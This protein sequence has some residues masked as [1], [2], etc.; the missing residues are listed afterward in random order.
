MAEIIKTYCESI[1]SLRLIGKR[2]TNADRQNGSF[3]HKWGQWFQSGWFEQLEKLGEAEGIENGYLGFMRVNED[4]PQNS[5]E[6]WI[7]LFTAP[8]TTAPE[9]FDYIDL[10][11]GK[12]GVCWIR[13]SDESGDIYRMH[14]KCV[15]SLKAMGFCGL[16]S[17]GEWACFF[18]RYNCPRFT[19]PDENG[20]VILDYCIYLRE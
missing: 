10:D 8:G 9:G 2:Y 5:F 17:H 18:E 15:N 7:G 13:G 20:L 6:Y 11:S 3:G 19:Q 14:E 1:S 12:L 16:N 4:D